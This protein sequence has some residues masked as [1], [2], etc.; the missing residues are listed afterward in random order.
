MVTYWKNEMQYSRGNGYFTDGLKSSI[1]KIPH[2]MDSP[3]RVEQ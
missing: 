1:E 2:A 3:W